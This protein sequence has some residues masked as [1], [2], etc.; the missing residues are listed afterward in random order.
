MSASTTNE[1]VLPDVKMHLVRPSE[2]VRAVITK[3]EPCTAGRKSATFVRHIEFDVSGTPL[4]GTCAAGQSIG[5][6]APGEDARGRPH[7][8]R[9]YSLASP[10]AGEDGAGRILATTV[11]RTIDEHWDS[12]KLF[13]GVASNYLC[14]CQVGDEIRVSGPSGKRFVLPVDVNAHDYLFV[15]TG[16]GIAPFRGMVFELL[17][18][19]C[20]RQ[21]T[22]IM[23]S[24]YATDL[25]Y[26]DVFDGLATTHQNFRYLTAI[27]RETNGEGNGK[28]YVQDRLRASFD[29]LRG[30]L[31]GDGNLIYVCGIAG[32][33]LGLFQEIAR[34]LRGP[35]LEGYMAIDP[36]IASEIDGWDRK[37]INRQ[38]KLTRRVMLEVYA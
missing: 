10:T 1:P 33:E 24:P 4:E 26:H 17:S 7:A 32:M 9:L 5:V 16:T 28:M 18:R 21:I 34:R 27:S 3:N 23:G 8:V 29:E 12:G 37:M 15:A 14:D 6:I 22:L 38:V 30:Q 2:P 36:A 35:A 25:L 31:E 20:R 11:K 19:G 13:L